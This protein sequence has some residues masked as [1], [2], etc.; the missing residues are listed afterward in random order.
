MLKRNVLWWML[1]FQLICNTFVTLNINIAIVSMTGTPSSTQEEPKVH[2]AI[3]P[4]ESFFLRDFLTTNELSSSNT[5]EGVI[6]DWSESEKNI[7]LSGYHWLNYISILP[8]GVLAHKFGSKIMAGY[9][10][11][12]SSTMSSLIPIVATY[13]PLKVAWLRAVQGVLSFM[14]VPAALYTIIGKWAPPQERGKFGAALYSGSMAGT[15]SGN[16]LFGYIAQYMN[17]VYVFHFTSI[18]GIIWSILWYTLIHDSPS[19]HPTITVEEKEYIESSLKGAT[20]STKTRIPWKS[21]LCSVPVI[22]T[23]LAAN[24]YLWAWVML[25]TYSPVYLK[26]IYGLD[27]N[28]IG[29]I[30]SIPNIVVSIL[31]FGIAYCIDFTLKR[32]LLNITTIRKMC[33][34]LG[35]TLASIPIII[36]AFTK[37]DLTLVLICFI[38]HCIVRVSLPFGATL[39]IIDISPEF[40]GITEGL[41]GTSAS[42]KIFLFTCVVN[43]FTGILEIKKLWEMVFLY[44]TGYLIVA[45]LLYLIFGTSE[46]EAWNF[47]N[48]N[49]K[50]ESEDIQDGKCEVAP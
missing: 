8:G 47:T 40:C 10:Q 35:T 14:S 12:I 19:Q 26:T 34:F 31:I 42:I 15:I 20:S 46:V 49:E 28:E 45:N 4:N 5:Q 13:G 1:L 16:V 38:I 2:A 27:S 32:K 44:S 6:F 43:Y 21:I 7:V 11:L 18:C 25:S 23:T 29:I 48:H 3:C 30:S 17:W 33:A 22:V 50:R 41:C 36:I 24:A 9:A 37:C 39:G